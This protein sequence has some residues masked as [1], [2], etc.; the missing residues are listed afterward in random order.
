MAKKTIESK[1]NQDF[2][3]WRFPKREISIGSQILVNQSEDALLFEN[4]LL[5]QIL[6][7]GRHLVESGNIP[8][9]DGIMRRSRK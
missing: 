3:A 1:F 5:C 6:D 4:G 8:G 9:L 7:P 2:I